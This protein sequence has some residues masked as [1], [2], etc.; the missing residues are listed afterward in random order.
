MYQIRKVYISGNGEDLKGSWEDGDGTQTI[1]EPMYYKNSLIEKE[2]DDDDDDDGDEHLYY[3]VECFPLSSILWAMNITTVDLL[4][5]QLDGHEFL[6]LETFPFDTI[7]I[8]VI[9]TVNLCILCWVER[10]NFSLKVSILRLILMRILF[11]VF[12]LK[13]QN[14]PRQGKRN[15][16]KFMKMEKYQLVFENSEYFLYLHHRYYTNDLLK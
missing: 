4:V 6:V 15:I 1:Y 7:H 8:K 10:Q 11:Q 9:Y 16:K 3:K 5:L 2:N 12:S 14:I 13:H